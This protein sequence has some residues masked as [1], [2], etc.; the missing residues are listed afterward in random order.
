MVTDYFNNPD[1]VFSPKERF[2]VIEFYKNLLRFPAC[3]EKVFGYYF[4]N[5]GDS[6]FPI[7]EYFPDLA[8]KYKFCIMLGDKDWI[9]KSNF[10]R[11][12]KNLPTNEYSELI[13]LKDCGHMGIFE[14][15]EQVCQKMIDWYEDNKDVVKIKS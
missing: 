3:G 2:W 5:V 12:I 7:D 6:D 15:P 11:S 9:E 1:F 14:D 8:K 10:E 13:E 4:T